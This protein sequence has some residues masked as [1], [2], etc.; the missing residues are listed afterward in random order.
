M[1]PSNCCTS[2]STQTITQNQ[3]ACQ[4]TKLMRRHVNADTASDAFGNTVA[5][6]T[7]ALTLPPGIDEQRGVT[8]LGKERTEVTEV[9]REQRLGGLRQGQ[10]Q[11]PAVLDFV[12]RQRKMNV[13]F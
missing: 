4:M 11:R 7:G 3:F 8:L 6:R 5:D 1:C 13:S 10:Q 2:G 9:F 12:F